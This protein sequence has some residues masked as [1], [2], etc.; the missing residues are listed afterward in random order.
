MTT[1]HGDAIAALLSGVTV[2]QDPPDP[3]KLAASAFPYVVLYLPPGVHSSER[4]ASAAHRA[5]I[6]FRTV[7]VA[8]STAQLD[9]LRA[10]VVARLALRRP[11]V[12]GRICSQIGHLSS[13]PATVDPDV[14]ERRLWIG[15][16]SWELVST[17]APAA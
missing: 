10:F 3:A 1:A 13:L 4:L 5:D 15:G 6:D 2:A 12:P 7:C 8:T 17:A 9:Y 11:V 16:D 14:P